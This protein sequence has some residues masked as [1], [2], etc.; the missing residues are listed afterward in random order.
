MRAER[1]FLACGDDAGVCTAT[2]LIHP[3]ACFQRVT[4]TVHILP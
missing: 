2:S 1:E 4:W 3:E